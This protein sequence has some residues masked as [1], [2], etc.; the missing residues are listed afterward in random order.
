MALA[1]APFASL[2]AS[3]IHDR[4]FS[5]VDRSHITPKHHGYHARL[6][7][8]HRDISKMKRQELTYKHVFWAFGE[9]VP[10]TNDL[11]TVKDVLEA[12]AGNKDK[13]Q[14]TTTLHPAPPTIS[15]H[16]SIPIG[17]LSVS[18]PIPTASDSVINTQNDSDPEEGASR[19]RKIISVIVIAGSI[20]S[21]ILLVGI[22]RV[23]NGPNLWFMRR[24]DPSSDSEAG[25]KSGKKVWDWQRL[26]NPPKNFGTKSLLPKKTEEDTL[27][28]QYDERGIERGTP[29]LQEEKV[30]V[31]QPQVKLI[32]LNTPHQS[33]VPGPPGKEAMPVFPPALATPVDI[34]PE[35]TP[36]SLGPVLSVTSFEDNIQYLNPISPSASPS[37]LSGSTVLSSP[38]RT[39]SVSTVPTLEGDPSSRHASTQQSHLSSEWDIAGAYGHCGTRSERSRS[40][41]AMSGLSTDSKE[42]QKTMAG[43]RRSGR[44]SGRTVSG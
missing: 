29:E 30:V 5:P 12:V 31:V 18:A 25:V 22:L 24:K 36:P 7:G 2:L 40:T 16:N 42:W 23:I 10:K 26:S 8:R 17:S 43:G 9:D 35:S 20:F 41:G 14:P 1:S 39:K 6:I 4:Q 21:L 38:T 3:P 15:L 19:K 33:I 27:R 32:Q 44:Y 11:P 28:R 13:E 34:S 37:Y